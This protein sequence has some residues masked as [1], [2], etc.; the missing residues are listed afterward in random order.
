MN[1]RGFNKKFLLT[2]LAAPALLAGSSIPAL[3]HDSDRGNGPERYGRVTL[4]VSGKRR[5][6]SYFVIPGDD[7][8]YGVD[9]RRDV[10]QM[11]AERFDLGS[12]PLLGQLLTPTLT[13]QFAEATDVGLL[14]LINH[15]IVLLPKI[16]VTAPRRHVW[17]THRNVVYRPPA[18]IRPLRLKSPLTREQVEAAPRI[19]KAVLKGNIILGI[20]P[21]SALD[22]MEFGPSASA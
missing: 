1:R 7:G 3:G 5:L 13:R 12:V 9:L 11:A 10:P 2:G 4:R 20:V 15:T 18:G 14:Y 22:D 6:I 17:I 19:G 21:P 8:P 16:A